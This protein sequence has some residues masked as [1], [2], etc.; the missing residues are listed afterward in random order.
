MYFW[1]DVAYFVMSCVLI[2]HGIR[3]YHKKRMGKLLYFV[4]GFALLA[5]S[6]LLQI[7]FQKTF[8]FLVMRALALI[9]LSLYAGFVFLIVAALKKIE[10]S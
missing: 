7:L 6:D 9:R 1:I 4:C 10:R 2:F 3:E 5:F 8:S